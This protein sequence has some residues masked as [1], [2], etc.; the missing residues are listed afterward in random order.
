MI[1][2]AVFLHV[3]ETLGCWIRLA[4]TTLRF[5]S[6]GGV[7]LEE[8]LKGGG[9]GWGGVVFLLYLTPALPTAA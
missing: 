3:N 2:Y 8:G 5:A 7:A 4:M 6:L 1:M 9:G